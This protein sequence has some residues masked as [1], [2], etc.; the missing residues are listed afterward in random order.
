MRH[1]LLVLLAALMPAAAQEP[2]IPEEKV[3]LFN[4]WNL[5]G[6]TVF[7]RDNGTNDPRRVFTV[8][9][10]K[11]VVTGEE[12]GA[13]TTV[14]EWR[15]YKLVVEWKWGGK[16]WPPRE[17]RAWDSGILLHAVGEPNPKR[18]GWLQSFEYQIIE[19][20]TG[21]MIPVAGEQRPRAAAEVRFGPDKQPYFEAGSPVQEFDRQ[22]VNW[23]GRDV[24][25]KDELG[26]RGMKDVEKKVGRWNRSEIIARGDTLTFYLNG[27]LVNRLSRLSQT[28]GKIQFQS[29]GA[30]IWFRKI[31]LEPLE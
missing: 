12:W 28:A 19:G 15:D 11:I 4:G 1:I 31:E 16:A 27:R 13:I 25:W 2:R 3:K 7:L 30:E 6:F 14:D 5:E 17:K 9:D 18:N 23:W 21:D 26:F 24:N 22:R 10:K 20:G 29:E 8:R